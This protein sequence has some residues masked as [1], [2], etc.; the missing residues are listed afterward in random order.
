[1]SQYVVL[2]YAGEESW[3]P[4]DK[5]AYDQATKEHMKFGEDDQSAIEIATP[6]SG[7]RRPP[8]SA[9]WLRR[10]LRHRQ[11]VRRD[12]GSPRRRPWRPPW[13][14]AHREWDYVLAATRLIR[15]IAAA[16]DCVQDPTRRRRGLRALPACGSGS[17]S[18]AATWRCPLTPGSAGAGLLALI[19]LSDASQ[20][21]AVRLTCNC[22]GKEVSCRAHQAARSCCRQR[23]RQRQRHGNGEVARPGTG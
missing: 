18:P 13:Q 6:S 19:R 4:V 1:M 3:P 7:Q 8:R 15:D 17:S 14:R 20:D 9:R 16:E 2:I 12:R 22:S 11:A 21:E 23:Q 5:D 10:P